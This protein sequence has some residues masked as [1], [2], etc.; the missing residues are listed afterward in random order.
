MQYIIGAVALAI[1]TLAALLLI[2]NKKIDKL[3]DE[4][5]TLKVDSET[6]D[7]KEKANASE[8]TYSVLKRAYDKFKSDHPE[9]FR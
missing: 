8:Q 5:S 4:N 6:K 1:T 7:V 2:K 3:Q 9:L